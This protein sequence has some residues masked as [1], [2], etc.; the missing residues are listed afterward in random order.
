M[1]SEEHTVV[2][3]G[4]RTLICP[5]FPAN[6]VWE[7][8]VPASHGDVQDEEKRLVER[9]ARLSRLGPGVDEKR[10]VFCVNSA[11]VAQLPHGVLEFPVHDMA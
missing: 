10:A 8:A 1:I 9:G 6:A 3:V 2:E 5:W 7:P 4:R 11:K